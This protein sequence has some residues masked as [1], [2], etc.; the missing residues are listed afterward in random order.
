MRGLVLVPCIWIL[1]YVWWRKQKTYQF[2]VIPQS[3]S[4]LS[5]SKKKLKISN[6]NISH[7]CEA[8]PWSGGV[9]GRDSLRSL[10]VS[11]PSS[12]CRFSLAPPVWAPIALS[13]DPFDS[14]NS[15]L[16]NPSSKLLL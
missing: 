6:T 3:K 8:N 11:I 16:L 13:E 2:I 14:I 12:T 10:I 9:P 1:K 7:I 5:L 4:V 15:T